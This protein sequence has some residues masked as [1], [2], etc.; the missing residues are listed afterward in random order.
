MARFVSRRLIS[1]P[2]T[3]HKAFT[4]RTVIFFF[5]PANKMPTATQSV[6]SR[7]GKNGSLQR[8][9]FSAPRRA[10]KALAASGQENY[11]FYNILET[12]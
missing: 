10:A 3:P 11:L 4:P 12:E 1:G 5:S 6:N 8:F 9:S 2:R 7:R